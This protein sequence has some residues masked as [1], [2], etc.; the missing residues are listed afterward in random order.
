MNIEKVKD[1]RKLKGILELPHL[2]QLNERAFWF[3]DQMNLLLQSV[4]LDWDSRNLGEYI[5][6]EG[7]Y[8]WNSYHKDERSCY[9]MSDPQYLF[10]TLINIKNSPYI[11]EY[12][13]S[14]IGKYESRSME[15]SFDFFRI[16]VKASG[17]E[18][19][20]IRKASSRHSRT[21]TTECMYFDKEG[22][23]VK[24]KIIKRED[25]VDSSYM[26][27][28]LSTRSADR[29][30]ALE[31]LANITHDMIRSETLEE[32]PEVGEIL[33]N[34]FSDFYEGKTGAE[35]LLEIHND[36]VV[37][38]KARIDALS[39][40]YFTEELKRY[41]FEINE[42]MLEKADIGSSRN[43][44]FYKV[45]P[46]KHNTYVLVG[47]HSKED[48]PTF[49]YKFKDGA[50]DEFIRRYPSPNNQIKIDYSYEGLDTESGL[51]ISLIIDAMKE[52]NGGFYYRNGP[53]F[54]EENIIF[55]EDYPCDLFD[56]L[57][58]IFPTIESEPHKKLIS[59]ILDKKIEKELREHVLVEELSPGVTSATLLEKIIK[60]V[61]MLSRKTSNQT[62]VN[63]HS[64]SV[65]KNNYVLNM[66]I[67]EG[68]IDEDDKDFS[69]SKNG[70]EKGDHNRLLFT[71]IDETAKKI[72]SPSGEMMSYARETEKYYH[73]AISELLEKSNSFDELLDYLR[74]LASLLNELTESLKS[75]RLKKDIGILETVFKDLG[76]LLLFSEVKDYPIALQLMIDFI[77]KNYGVG[78]KVK[79]F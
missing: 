22:N 58:V 45:I 43:Q 68:L 34:V 62:E 2:N 49:I 31:V 75:A 18:I 71:L 4:G 66:L 64:D 51:G 7:F 23:I 70:Y 21:A 79:V 5:E 24:E 28:N 38:Q 60:E 44:S 67:E 29:V 69:L 9:R 14:Y 76:Q 61:S 72:E 54:T 59:L 42:S 36:N 47:Q 48:Y 56:S 53:V 16:K 26:D 25:R 15:N 39:D 35:L 6:L 17:A 57:P 55:D 50:E 3:N 52:S 40:D 1:I 33:N 8:S 20:F 74:E 13:D 46:E 77:V 41:A 63:R 78:D 11:E 19:V 27:R 73:K 10:G 32:L 65:V 37:E 30:E 12:A